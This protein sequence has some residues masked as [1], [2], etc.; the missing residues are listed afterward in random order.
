M[1]RPRRDDDLERLV[2]LLRAVYGSDGY[3]AHWPRDPT[4]WLANHRTIGAWVGEEQG[5]LVGHIGLTA[6]DPD[7]AWPQW[8]DALSLPIERLAVMRRLFVAPHWRRRGLGTRLMTCAARTAAEHRL[9]LVLDVADHNHAAIAFWQRHGWRQVGTAT[10]PAGDEGRS[11]R[12]LLFA[13][14]F[15]GSA[16]T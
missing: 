6:P 11:L 7:R 14:S 5:D 2:V 15:R 9:H 16:A 4:R 12:L 10:V 8:Q 1:I 13:G 3:P